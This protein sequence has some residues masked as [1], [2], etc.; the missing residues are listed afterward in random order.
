MRADQLPR[1]VVDLRGT[2]DELARAALRDG[3]DPHAV[4]HLVER[5]TQLSGVFHDEADAVSGAVLAVTRALGG[6][7]RRHGLARTATAARR[8]RRPARRP[9]RRAARPARRRSS[10]RSSWPAGSTASTTA[11]WPS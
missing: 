2:L 8:P 11:P 9:H 6:R 4:E 1:D 7:Q 5:A 10:A 3:D